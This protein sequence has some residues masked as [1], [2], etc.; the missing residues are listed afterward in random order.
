MIVV[1][2]LH[3]TEPDLLVGYEHQALVIKDMDEKEIHRMDA[4]KDGWSHDKL[5]TIDYDSISP[6]WDAYLGNQW[7]GSSEV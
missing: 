5:E 6:E 7:I 1:R 4:P 2:P 3:D